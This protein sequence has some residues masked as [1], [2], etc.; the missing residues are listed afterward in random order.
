MA[1]SLMDL[2]YNRGDLAPHMSE[3]TLNYH[4]G[5]HHQGY[6]DK[7]NGMAEGTKYAAMSLKDVVRAANEADDTGVFNNA[8]QV[9]NHDFLWHSL[10]PD[11]GG[12]PT[13]DV[14]DAI[15][16]SFGGIDEFRD[17]FSEAATSQFGSGWAWLVT[18]GSRLEVLNTANADN[19]MLV[20][21]TPLITLDVWEHAYYLDY[22]ND[23]RK[24]VDTFL[25]H[26]VNWQFAN[27]NLASA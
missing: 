2:P 26:M 7:L 15:E 27:R 9:L 4:Y 14:K 10:T 24:F 11:G 6:V 23:R 18:D 22:Q 19:P 13:G 12:K 25:D 5:K 21:K 8:A 20:G 16:E 17:A 1:F 3:D